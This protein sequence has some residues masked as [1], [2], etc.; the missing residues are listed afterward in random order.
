MAKRLAVC[1]L[2]AALCLV[3]GGCW[4]YESLDQINIVVG[5][6]VD[7]D[8]KSKQYD[9][10]FELA[11]LAKAQKE[12]AIKG[13][14]IR[15]RGKTIFD[16]VRNAKRQDADRLFFGSCSVLIIS[17]ELAREQGIDRVIEWFLRDGESRETMYVAISQN[18]TAGEILESSESS[19]GIISASLFDMLSEDLEI[20]G[21]ADNIKLYQVHNTLKSPRKAVLIPVVRRIKV[22]KEKVCELNGEAVIKEGRLTGFLPPEQT[23][24]ALLIENKLKGGIITLSSSG[25]ETEDISLE[26]LKNISRKSFRHEDGKITVKIETDTKVALGE[27]QNYLDP[28]DQK[29]IEKIQKATSLKIESGVRDLIHTMQNEYRADTFGFGEM[30]YEKKPKLWK[31]LS[32]SWD[33]IYPTVEIDVTA[34]V[35]I[36][37]AALIKCEGN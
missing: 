27:N 25:G 5:A 30:I 26:I 4:N 8:K 6:A 33:R 10:S 32:S 34:K 29:V 9:V 3:Q 36:I 19:S 31:E 12:S 20:T 1:L 16:A 14:I 13:R 17:Q 22:G 23:R 15:S 37:N 28:M 11:D 7:Y 18:E 21:T 24:Y 2:A 35:E